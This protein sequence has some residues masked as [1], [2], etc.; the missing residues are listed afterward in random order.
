M[1]TVQITID[2]SL[3]C[4]IDDVLMAEHTS[5]S[6]FIRQALEAALRQYETHQ[7]DR[8]DQEGYARIPQRLI[9]M[10]VWISEQV[11]ER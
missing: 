6:A 4:Q 8:Q 7:W 9:E 1:E 11:W 3:L 10:E 5:R 2:E